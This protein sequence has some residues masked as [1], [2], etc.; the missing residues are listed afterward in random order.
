[1]SA[2]RSAATLPPHWGSGPWRS[3][4]SHSLGASLLMGKKLGAIS[5]FPRLIIF[6]MKIAVISD[7]P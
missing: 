5:H 6:S 1:M 2:G 7:T 4:E 3:W